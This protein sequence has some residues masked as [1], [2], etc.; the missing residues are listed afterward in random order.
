ML[1]VLHTLKKHLLSFYMLSLLIELQSNKETMNDA[2]HVV[3]IKNLL[4]SW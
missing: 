1:H 2:M 4:I 3:S